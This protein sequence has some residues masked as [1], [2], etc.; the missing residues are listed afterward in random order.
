M[1]VDPND[2]MDIG[3]R[4]LSHHTGSFTDDFSHNRN[5]VQ[6]ITKIQSRHLRN[7]IAGYITRKRLDTAT[8]SL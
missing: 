1:S 3:N 7:R 6:E 4:L 2:V 5:A 8:S